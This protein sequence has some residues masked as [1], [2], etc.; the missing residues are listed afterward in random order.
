MRM[1]R[2]VISAAVVVATASGICTTDNNVFTVSL[3]L[4][5][6]EL[7]YYTFAECGDETNPTIGIEIGQT[8]T[9][10]QADR[11]NYYH[12][13]GFAYGPDG[14]H[15]GLSELE[16]SVSDGSSGCESDSTCPAPMYFSGDA[17]LGSYS[18]IPDVKD[19][20]TGEDDTGLDAYES[21]FFYPITEW[22][23]SPAFSIQ[24]R[25]DDETF[26]KDLFYFCHVSLSLG[27][28]WCL[29]WSFC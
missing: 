26:E 15:A 1:I 22:A 12:P 13:M 28:S 25:F 21:V 16:P 29:N 18:N 2:S 20:T 7:G 24:L 4:F 27:N 23:A 8:Y 11:S 10:V 14:A 17:Y 9:F 3:N 19:V 5:A 6:S